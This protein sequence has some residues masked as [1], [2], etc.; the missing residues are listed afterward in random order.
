[1]ETKTSELPHI[2]N[3]ADLDF[4][5]NEGLECITNNR[6]VELNLYLETQFSLELVFGGKFMNVTG[7]GGLSNT[8]C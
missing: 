8:S 4:A 1:M 5:T 3:T 2:W 7:L 6:Y